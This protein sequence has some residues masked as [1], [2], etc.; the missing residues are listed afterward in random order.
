MKETLYYKKLKNNNVQCTL[1][2]HFCV[3][4]E[5]NKGECKVRENKSGKLYSLVYSKPCS[6]AIDPVEKKPLFHFLPGSKT[7]SVGTAGCNLKC[8]F[9][10]NYTTSQVEPEKV[11]SINL[12]PEKVVEQA[13]KNDC[14]TIAYTYNEP[15]VFY[16]YVIDTAKIAKK[17]GLKNIIVSNGYINE[18]PLKRLAMF[19]DGAN[20][21]LKSFN[22]EFYKEVGGE[23]EPVLR[24]LKILKKKWLEITNLI[25]PGRNDDL[26][27]IEKMC[28]W[29][30]ENLGKS[31]P[32]HF[33][34]FFPN[35]LME[36]VSITTLETLKKAKEIAEKYLDYVYIGNISTLKDENT[37]CKKCKKIVIERIGFSIRK[38][39][40]KKGACEC[41]NL[42]EGVWK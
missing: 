27:E 20:I 21:D 22:E 40:L 6:V 41:G 10:Q 14:K 16:E 2:P 7:F 29:I 23:L 35:Y 18:E 9:C 24:S 17:K 38:N 33:S 32:L 37:Y 3:I 25:I 1:C 34:R 31:V 12:E 15:T 5:R 11:K 36:N 39:K 28:E 30:K 8:L 26:K 42:I 19:I 4:K 13:I